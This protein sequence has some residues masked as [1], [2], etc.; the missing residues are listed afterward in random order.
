[1]RVGCLVREAEIQHALQAKNQNIKQQKQYC[2][3]INKDFLNGP[4][5]KYKHVTSELIYRTEA[6][7]QT[8][9]TCG[10]EGGE[11]GW[12]GSLRLADINCYIE[13]EH[14]ARFCC[15]ARGTMFNIL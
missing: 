3:K 7:S 5:Q 9:Q 6:D 11:V 8:E 15:R 13:D 14:T 2:N 1:M 4:H 10:V 12:T